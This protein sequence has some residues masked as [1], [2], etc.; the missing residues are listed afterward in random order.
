LPIAQSPLANPQWLISV[1]NAT[2]N[3]NRNP[4]DHDPG[5]VPEEYST[6]SAV[7]IPKSIAPD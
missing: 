5:P 7:A 3:R 1:T 4:K 2:G 6:P